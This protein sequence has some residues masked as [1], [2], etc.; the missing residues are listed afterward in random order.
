MDLSG[1]INGQ[2]FEH[3]FLN[4]SGVHCQSTTELD[5][6]LNHPAVG[7]IVT[8]SATLEKRDGNPA[9]RY[10]ELADGSINSMGLPNF[11]YDYY[12]DYVKQSHAKP[13]IL[14]VAGLSAA[15]DV[16]LLHQIQ[17]S[18]YA[19][20]TELNLSCPNVI[21]K[22]QMAYDYAGTEALLKEIFAFFKKPLGVKL[23]PY[24][25][26]VHFDQIAAVLNQFPLTHV[27]TINSVGNGLWVDV[28]SESVVIKPKGGFGGLGGRMVLLTA[29]A[30]VR[31]LRQRLNDS[32]KIIGTGGVKT[33]ADVFAHILCGAELVSV[34]TQLQVEGLSVYDR[35]TTELSRIMAD[36]GY[37]SLSDFRGKLKTI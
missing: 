36:K 37:H 17:A 8:K 19:G 24:F 10:Y 23:P 16:Q 4:A 12:I 18:D 20:L 15:D 31:A 14:S 22:P 6:L 2:Q 35:L 1:Q 11:G 3:L 25:D 13:T 32:I 34:G 33:G 27:N 30:N 21:G 26:L 29:L 9:P 28:A 5:D 7:G